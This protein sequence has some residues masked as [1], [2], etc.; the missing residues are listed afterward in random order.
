MT[1]N[2]PRATKSVVRFADVPKRSES[3]LRVGYS[4]G[5]SPCAVSETKNEGR[6]TPLFRHCS[7]SPLG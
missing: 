4:S 1:T 3:C 5:K 2:G 6:V 7:S